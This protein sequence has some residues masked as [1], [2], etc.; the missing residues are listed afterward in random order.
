MEGLGDKIRSHGRKMP[1]RLAKHCERI[2]TALA[3]GCLV[4]PW[5]ETGAC[6]GW[7]LLS[8]TLKFLPPLKSVFMF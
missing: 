5:Q 6:R 4:N 2:F 3:W 1:A 7:P 8:L